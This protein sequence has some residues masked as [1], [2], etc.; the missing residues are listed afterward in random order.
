MVESVADFPFRQ[1]RNDPYLILDVMMYIKRKPLIKFMFA[2]SKATRNFLNFKYTA[3]KNSF[4]NEG[5]IT[6]HITSNFIGY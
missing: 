6:H 4:I 2:V 3:I 5:L 1:L